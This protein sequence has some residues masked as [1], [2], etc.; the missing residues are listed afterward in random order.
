[1]TILKEAQEQNAKLLRERQVN[2]TVRLLRGIEHHTKSIKSLQEKIKKVENGDFFST[3]QPM[4]TIS[5]AIQMT[6]QVWCTM[7]NEYH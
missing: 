5:N 1:M 4:G 2:E 3:P 6:N 7:C